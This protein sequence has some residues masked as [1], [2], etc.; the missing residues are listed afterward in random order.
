MRTGKCISCVPNDGI[1]Q[2]MCM[3]FPGGL[4]V[5]SV[6]SH[7]S[8]RCLLQQLDLH[9]VNQSAHVSFYSVLILLFNWRITFIFLYSLCSLPSVLPHH[10]S[11][12]L[13]VS[14]RRSRK[15]MRMGRCRERGSPGDW[16][17]SGTVSCFHF[18][19]GGKFWEDVHEIGMPLLVSDLSLPFSYSHLLEGAT[20]GCSSL[21]KM[22]FIS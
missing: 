12:V 16:L 7:R 15:C 10:P 9:Y 4:D 3:T 18:C 6:K 20:P 13:L 17:L 2:N 22:E 8:T 5:C 1:L 11:S 19:F 14:V 21:W